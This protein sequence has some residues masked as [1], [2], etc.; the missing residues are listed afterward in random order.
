MEETENMIREIKELM[1]LDPTD[2]SLPALLEQLYATLH[3]QQQSNQCVVPFTIDD[4][5]YLLP[6]IVIDSGSAQSTVFIMT[7]ITEDT[8]PCTD[9]LAGRQCE[10]NQHGITFAND[11]LLP[12]EALLQDEYHLDQRVWVKDSDAVY[13]MARVQDALATGEWRV[14]LAS[15]RQS[16]TVSTLI[17]VKDLL[18]GDEPQQEVSS[19]EEVEVEQRQEGWAS[20][21]AHTTGFGAKML[22]KM[23][24]VTGQGLGRENQG[25]VNPVEA[26]KR[27]GDERLG[28]GGEKKKKPV[29][30]KQQMPRGQDM[31]TMMNKMLSNPPS[32]SSESPIPNAKR[33]ERDPKAAQRELAKLQS[34]VAAT[35]AELSQAMES[36]RRNRGSSMEQQFKDQ[37]KSVGQKLEQL[38]T[39]AS[40]LQNSIKQTKDREKMILF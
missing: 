22:A 12:M 1:A 37:A 29:K 16:R 38:K 10:C 13:V 32:S 14:E 33:V 9:Y 25:R 8:V 4:H 40:T 15:T 34:K 26:A 35:Q 2:Q 20:W 3:D 23:G 24:Y 7:P 21:Q 17:P 11:E 18:E 5:C 6:A 30:Q 27:R 36:V 28:L 39:Q 31:F 19:D